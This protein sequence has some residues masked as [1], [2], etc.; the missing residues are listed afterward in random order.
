MQDIIGLS[1]AVRPR[2]GIC[3]APPACITVPA[4]LRITCINAGNF[5]LPIPPFAH[6]SS[7]YVEW[8]ARYSIRGFTFTHW[9]Q[10]EA[11]QSIP[12]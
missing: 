7:H 10:N 2:H 5:L 9:V 6:L 12:V 11:P 4:H 3:Y 1:T 8:L